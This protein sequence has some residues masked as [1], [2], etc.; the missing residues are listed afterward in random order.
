[1]IRIIIYYYIFLLFIGEITCVF[2]VSG[3]NLLVDGKQHLIQG[4]CYNPIPIGYGPDVKYEQ[5][6]S[7]DSDRQVWG[8]DLDILYGMGANTIRMYGYENNVDHTEFLNA[9]LAKGIHV[10]VQYWWD[11][12]KDLN[13][14][15]VLAGWINMITKQQHPAIGMWIIHNEL[16]AKYTSQADLDTLFN[17]I[18]RMVDEVVK[19]EGPNHRPVTTTLAN[20]DNVLDIITKYNNRKIDVWSVQ[21]YNGKTFN[22]FFDRYAPL[23]SKPLV[24]T[25]FGIDAYDNSK[26]VLDEGLQS[27]YAYSLFQE[28]YANRNVTSGGTVFAYVDEWWK[29]GNN[30]AH[31][32][33]GTYNEAFPDRLVNEEYF[34]LFTPQK[35]GDGPDI[36]VARSVVSTLTTLWKANLN[37]PYIPNTE[38]NTPPTSQTAN[39]YDPATTYQPTTTYQ[40]ANTYQPATTYQSP[41]SEQNPKTTSQSIIIPQTEG[42]QTNNE[43]DA[44]NNNNK[45]L[46]LEGW[47]VIVIVVGSIVGLAIINIIILVLL[48]KK[49]FTKREMQVPVPNTP[50]PPAPHLKPVPP[51]QDEPVPPPK[52]PGLPSRKVP[53]PV[54]QNPRRV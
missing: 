49:I 21:L 44:I 32:A 12:N 54:P 40:T 6:G 27:D 10:L 1:M 51:P 28:L 33:C 38:T 14:P 22:G 5:Y 31:D 16:N 42:V 13:D 45:P 46:S 9:A 15:S 35:N 39:T 34:G 18:D 36:L 2:T 48:R 23:S 50:P 47:M 24:V 8:R 26:G 3:R 7:S 20:L 43:T 52:M 29:C 4:A 17:L 25:E 37:L 30:Y 11:T 41:Q 19:I 53:P